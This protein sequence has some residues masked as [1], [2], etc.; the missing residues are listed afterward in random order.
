LASDGSETLGDR[1]KSTSDEETK[2]NA[3]NFISAK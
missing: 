2:D 3:S 1:F